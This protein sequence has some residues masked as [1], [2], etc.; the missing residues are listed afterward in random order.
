MS[1]NRSGRPT[2]YEHKASP[3]SSEKK[4]GQQAR[5][6]DARPERPAAPQPPPPTSEG[7]TD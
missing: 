7:K 6:G 3:G 4:A 5:P 2:E 1:E